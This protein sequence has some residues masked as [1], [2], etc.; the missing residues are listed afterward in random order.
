MLSGETT[1]TNV[2]VFGLIRPGL[3]PTIYS[4]RG[5]HANHYITAI[6]LST[7]VNSLSD[8]EITNKS[9]HSFLYLIVNGPWVYK[10]AYNNISVLWL[11]VLLAE[12]TLEYSETTTDFIRLYGLNIAIIRNRT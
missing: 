11:S 9:T 12:K 2:I 6:Q 10:F 7:M 5:E 3:D 8:S 1:N 4:T